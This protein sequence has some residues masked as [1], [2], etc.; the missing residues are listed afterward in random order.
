MKTIELYVRGKLIQYWINKVKLTACEVCGSR[1]NLCVHHGGENTFIKL[2]DDTMEFLKLEYKD[3]KEYEEQEINH[4]CEV[5][6]GKHYMYATPITLCVNCHLEHHKNNDVK[7]SRLKGDRLYCTK[8]E[9]L[10]SYSQKRS[11]NVSLEKAYD[12]NKTYDFLKTN[13]DK[14]FLI[15]GYKNSDKDYILSNIVIY[16]TKGR[17]IKTAT[18]LNLYFEEYQIPYRIICENKKSNGIRKV[19][20]AITSKNKY[21]QNI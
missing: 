6:I 11:L 12:V 9:L 18:S 1:D 4:I 3:F 19:K 2:L 7:L 16:D 14:T 13:E 10:N 15:N 8:N 21:I 5:V 17:R 20:W